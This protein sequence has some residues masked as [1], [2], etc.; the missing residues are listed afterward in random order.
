MNNTTRVIAIAAILLCGCKS[1]GKTASSTE[2]TSQIEQ[3]EVAGKTE[4]T[5]SAVS[6]PKLM[7]PGPIDPIWEDGDII[8]I[9]HI[10]QFASVEELRESPF[11]PQLCSLYPSLSD[12]DALSVDTGRGDLWFISPRE[13]NTSLA[14][15]EYNMKMFTEEQ[16]RGSGE[17]YFR[18]EYAKPMLLRMSADDPGTV[19]ISAVD[20]NGHALSWIPTQSP[21]DNRLRNETGV[22]NITYNPIESFIDMGQDY[23]LAGTPLRFYADGQIRLGD[24]L[25]RYRSFH[26]DEGGV[27]FLFQVADKEGISTISFDESQAGTAVVIP[28][29]GYDFG[30][31]KGKSAKLEAE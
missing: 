14:V 30:I 9:A 15:N 12:I 19:D 26:L 24:T 4:V 20:N 10:G 8:A 5:A 31:G 13:E 16:E 6:L 7:M 21:S 18:T 1:N 28:L 11:Y 27:A 25:G 23:S 17:I 3:T 29:Q 22:Q 2:A